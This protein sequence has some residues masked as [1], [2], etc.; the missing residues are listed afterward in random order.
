MF[1]A[2]IKMILAA[3]HNDMRKVGIVDM[4]I[5]SEKSFEDNFNNL[6]EIFRETNT[7]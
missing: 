4:C 6:C 7:Y 3:E 5:N 2:G 1:E